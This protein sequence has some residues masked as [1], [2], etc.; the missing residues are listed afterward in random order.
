[1]KVHFNNR[2]IKCRKTIFFVDYN[3]PRGT[4]VPTPMCE[5]LKKDPILEPIG[6]FED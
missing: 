2:N 6:M 1:M 5:I 3:F 4:N